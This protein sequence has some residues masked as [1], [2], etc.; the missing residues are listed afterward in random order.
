MRFLDA[1]IFLRY[2]G[3]VASAVGEING[4]NTKSL[5]EKLL[6]VAR[7]TGKPFMSEQRIFQAKR[8]A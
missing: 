2:L 4:T 5:Y 1:N 3:E 6:K 8:G 7:K